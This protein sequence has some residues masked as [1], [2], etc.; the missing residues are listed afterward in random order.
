MK[1]V[2]YVQRPAVCIN[3]RTGCFCRGR[4]WQ[5]IVVV[6]TYRKWVNGGVRKKVKPYLNASKAFPLF[7]ST[8]TASLSE[9]SV[10]VSFRTRVIGSTIFNSSI[11]SAKVYVGS[12]C[13][14]VSVHPWASPVRWSRGSK[15]NSGSDLIA[16]NLSWNTTDET[17]RQVSV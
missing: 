17:L 10:S 4:G 3:E 11:M 14:F 15:T 2:W 6:G 13:A 5:R 1:W 16:S 12:V 7:L 9:L 8:T